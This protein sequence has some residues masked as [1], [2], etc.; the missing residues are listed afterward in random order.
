LPPGIQKKKKEEGLKREKNPIV[1]LIASFIY[2]LGF[3]GIDFVQSF[4]SRASHDAWDLDDPHHQNFLV[5]NRTLCIA[6]PLPKLP[7]PEVVIPTLS[8][9]EDE[10]IINSVVGNTIS[11]YSLESRLR[12]CK[13][14]AS[15][16]REAL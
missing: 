9:E 7:D 3:F 6:P 1:S 5:D 14:A 2:L 11:S 4:I 10:E 16:R 8:F 15:I 13:R 12:D